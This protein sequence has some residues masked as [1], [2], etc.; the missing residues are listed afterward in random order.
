MIREYSWRDWMSV[1][2]NRELY[3]RNMKE[4]LRQFQLEKKRR[5]D[6]IRYAE[7]MMQRN[8]TQQIQEAVSTA[9][10]AASSAGGAGGGGGLPVSSTPATPAT[11]AVVTSFLAKT[12]IDD[13]T[14]ESSLDTFVKTLKAES[15]WSDML[16]FYPFVTD[17]STNSEIFEQFKFNLVDANS[18]KL[19]EFDGKFS[20]V[21]VDTNGISDFGDINTLKTGFRPS[22]ATTQFDDGEAQVPILSGGY[23]L[24]TLTDA[25]F[26]IISDESGGFNNNMIRVT[27]TVDGDG[28]PTQLNLRWPN[29]STANIDTTAGGDIGTFMVS[30]EQYNNGESESYRVFRISSSGYALTLDGVAA[31]NSDSPLTL[32]SIESGADN[33]L[34]NNQISAY[35]IM[36]AGLSQAQMTTVR[37]AVNQLQTDLGRAT[38]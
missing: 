17:K 32:G 30:G 1:P 21:T 2:Q 15:L 9:A 7:F 20:A 36:N 38:H 23:Y 6:Q 22:S 27:R 35:F 11:D 4:G 24:R 33:V 19:T 18:N 3:N 34:C 28:N 13:S 14:I 10:A 29:S 37:D 16:L 8:R 5:D 25:N 12:L 31:I 26:T